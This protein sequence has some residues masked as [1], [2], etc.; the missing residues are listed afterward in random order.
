MLGSIS[1]RD[2]LGAHGLWVGSIK[3]R[4][5]GMDVQARFSAILGW[6]WM[7]DPLLHHHGDHS[8]ASGY[9]TGG[10]SVGTTAVCPVDGE[11]DLFYFAPATTSNNNLS[12]QLDLA[13]Q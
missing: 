10:F 3:E 4:E 9:E 13:G 8:P 5:E 1:C 2:F 6:M 7:L 12:L 11:M